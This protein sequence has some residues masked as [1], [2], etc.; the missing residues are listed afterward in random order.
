MGD[1]ALKG[2]LE[3]LASAIVVLGFFDEVGVGGVV[4]SILDPI[5]SKPEGEG[6]GQLL[7]LIVVGE[8]DLAPDRLL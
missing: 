4:G 1:D 8:A 2:S 3:G 5:R 7:A 6:S